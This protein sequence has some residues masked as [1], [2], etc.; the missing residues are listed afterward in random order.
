MQYKVAITPDV[1]SA[2]SLGRY[3][4][5]SHP[6]ALLLHELLDNVF[7]VDRFGNKCSESS[8]RRC[9]KSGNGR[10]KD[11]L[12]LL[13]ARKK[14][15]DR[16][17]L[18]ALPT[19]E[20]QWIDLFLRERDANELLAIIHSPDVRPSVPAGMP[21]VVNIYDFLESSA[22]RK[23]RRSITLKKTPDEYHKYLGNILGPAS[24]A[25]LIDPYL[26][27]VE[28]RY[29]NT[30]V[31]AAHA[32]GAWYDKK[33]TRQ[34]HIHTTAE[35]QV[36]EH[37]VRYDDSSK[38]GSPGQKQAVLDAAIRLWEELSHK[39][40]T[41]TG[42]SIHVWFWKH[43]PADGSASSAVHDRYIMTE[44]SAIS[45]PWGLD[46]SDSNQS[47]NATTRWTLLDREDWELLRTEFPLEETEYRNRES[48][49]RSGSDASLAAFY[50]L[51]DHIPRSP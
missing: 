32:L 34:L 6:V 50:Q 11:A 3:P 37:E 29:T 30:V 5:P 24:V 9:K 26:N 42:V 17:S 39:V 45:A 4:S 51:V 13:V 16:S 1:F 23:R 14:Y 44:F 21:P 18:E 46:C 25:R 22:W 2:Q 31:L 47:R 19:S 40:R 43:K 41:E 49:R 20:Q 7:V 27:A 48:I 33:R 35:K 28:D 36:N 8:H 38:V 15:I 12:E 10:L